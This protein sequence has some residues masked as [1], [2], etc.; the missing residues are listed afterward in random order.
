MA[1]KIDKSVCISCGQCEAI[2]PVQAP[3][4]KGEAYEI[5]TAKCV[6]CG[7]C[8]ENCPVQAISAE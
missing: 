8:A 4:L 6:S 5:D 1:Y 2:C 3:S 7:A